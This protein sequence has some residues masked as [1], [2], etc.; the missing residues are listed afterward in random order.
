MNSQSPFIENI[1]E[2][3]VISSY[4]DIDPRQCLHS[5]ASSEDTSKPQVLIL[6]DVY[7]HESDLLGYLLS[8]KEI[9]YARINSSYIPNDLTVS[10]IIG[11]ES[12]S[13]FLKSRKQKC[14]LSFLKVILQR[15]FSIPN[16]DYNCILGNIYSQ[17]W[18]ASLADITYRSDC[19]HI[20][21]I[22]AVQKL[23][24][25]I[26]QLDIAKKSSFNIPDSILSNV[27]LDIKSFVK[28][29]GRCLY[30]AVGH[31]HVIHKGRFYNF[32]AKDLMV[33]NGI[34]DLVHPLLVQKIIEG[35]EDIRLTFVR[36]K[37]FFS[38]IIRPNN[39]EHI[40]YKSSSIEN[41][42]FDSFM[43]KRNI[44][45]LARNLIGLSELDYGSIDFLVK[46]GEWFFLEI[47]ERPDWKWLQHRNEP[48]IYNELISLIESKLTKDI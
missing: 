16:K 32:Y 15:N 31:H 37:M 42:S 46:D 33:D 4:P 1:I 41:L 36:K 23:L 22:S 24:N 19:V 47:N 9:P 13:S 18:K 6:S 35:A 40:D 25:P 45:K 14:D 34:E 5:I 27:A 11:S 38:R 8:Q 44:V 30:K 48:E 12:Y 7:D 28:K 3:E 17:E 21:P 26:Y 39:S 29:H 2:G 10:H 20:N 43:P